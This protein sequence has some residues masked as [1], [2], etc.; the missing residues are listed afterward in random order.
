MS[1]RSAVRE[2][3]G[4]VHEKTPV[5]LG[6]RTKPCFQ[7]LSVLGESWPPMMLARGLRGV[8]RLRECS[9][10]ASLGPEADT[11]PHFRKLRGAEKWLS[12]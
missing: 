10:E 7:A 5:A 6:K 9:L 11:K 1:S 3:V 8:L 4:S 12:R 2:A